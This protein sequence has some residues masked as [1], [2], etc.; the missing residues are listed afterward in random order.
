MSAKTSVLRGPKQV[1]SKS[2]SVTRSMT[3]GTALCSIPRG[4]RLLGI[5][6]SGV[7]S[8]AGTTATIQFGTNATSTDLTAAENVL[9][10]GKGNGGFIGFDQAQRAESNDIKI[11]VIYAETGTASSVGGW[12]ATVLYTAGNDIADDDE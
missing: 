2:R 6:L 4:S 12:V 5:T 11:Y 8:D 7:A 3:T 9:A 1:L 10:A